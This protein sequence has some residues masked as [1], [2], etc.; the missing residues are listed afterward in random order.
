MSG[1]TTLATRLG[2]LAVASFTLAT[3]ALA[4]QHTA[5]PD[6][7]TH[8]QHMAQMEKDAA[9]KE[10]GHEAMGFDQ[11]TTSHHFLIEATGGAIAVNVN[12]PGD[13]TGVRQIRAHLTEI[14]ASFKAG[15]FSKPF[16]THGEQ[17]AGVVVLQRLKSDMTYT[18]ADTSLGGIVRITTANAEALAALHE[19][20]RYQIT[21]HK[22]GD[23]LVR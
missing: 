15:D 18:Y 13:A 2:I 5:M 1:M 3:P 17:P 7:M 22:T 21:E 23:P 20:L 12:T 14:A 4:Q 8:E 6:G 11:D 9:M 10:H 19:F 16:M